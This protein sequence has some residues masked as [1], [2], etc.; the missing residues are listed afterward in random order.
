MKLLDRD[1]YNLLH[2]ITRFFFST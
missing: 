2:I 1:V